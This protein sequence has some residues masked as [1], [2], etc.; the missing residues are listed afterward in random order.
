MER[1]QMLQL[2]RRVTILRTCATITTWPVPDFPGIGDPTMRYLETVVSS[3]LAFAA[4]ALVVEVVS[5]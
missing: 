4:L 1:V 3:M 5:L 2:R